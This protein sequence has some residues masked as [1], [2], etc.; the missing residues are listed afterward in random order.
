MSPG[1]SLAQ[2]WG[3]V[4]WVAALS[5]KVPKFIERQ[6][7]C[8]FRGSLHF[9]NMQKPCPT[10]LMFVQ[11]SWKCNSNGRLCFGSVFEW[12]PLPETAPYIHHDSNMVTIQA[13]MHHIIHTI[14][15][16]KSECLHEAA[17][18]EGAGHRSRGAAREPTDR[19]RC[20]STA[21]ASTTPRES[22]AGPRGT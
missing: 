1:E 5:G 7:R 22:H 14:C 21:R 9:Y 4:P 6:N 16:I 2:S 3:C 11:H 18:P 8:P 17:G 15:S 20:E 13:C 10:C 19:H 12:V